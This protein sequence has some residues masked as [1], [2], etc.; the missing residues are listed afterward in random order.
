M[1]NHR[2]LI[3]LLVFLCCGAMAIMETFIQP[4]YLLKS[5]SK[6]IFF[7][8]SIALYGLMCRDRSIRSLF[9]RSDLRHAVALGVGVYLLLIGGF[10]VLRPFIHLDTIAQGLK[11]KEHISA[12]NFLFVALYISIFNSFL[13]E[14]FFRGFA[15]VTLRKY[16]PE[17]AAQIFSA[18]AFSVYHVFIF[19]G[20]FTPWIF[21]LA[22]VGL[23]IAGLFF[24]YLDRKGSIFPSWLVHISG[25][26][27]I[28]TVGLIMFGM[29]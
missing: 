23:F 5:M 4:G 18:A 27:A 2:A 14:L 24:N 3:P 10:W 13:E 29:L 21:T 1:K 11:E 12:V 20:W 16:W 9:C 6:I 7:G 19:K 17:L 25:N 15:Y 28:N 8:F 26:L 22:L